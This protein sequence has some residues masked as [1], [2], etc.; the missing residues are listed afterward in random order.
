ETSNKVAGLLLAPE[1]VTIYTFA[2]RGGAKSVHG[3]G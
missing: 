1:K 3:V 2:R